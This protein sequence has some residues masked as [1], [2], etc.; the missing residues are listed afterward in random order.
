MDSM[1]FV[2]F[3]AT[4]DLAKRKIFPALYN[5]YLD[6]KLPQPISIIGLGRGNLTHIEFQE[7]V[8]ESILAFSRRLE[9]DAAGMGD[10]LNAFRYS[11][12]NVNH[13]EDYQ[14]LLQLVK[15][16]EEELRIKDNRMFYLSVAPEFFDIIALNIRSSGLGTTNGWKRLMIEKPFGHDLQSARELNEKLSSAF[17]EEEIFRI[18]HYLGKPMVQN[19]EALEFANP[20][21]Q[22]IWNRE[23]IANVQITASETV[24]VETRAGYYDQAGAIRDMVQNHMLQ[25]L[26][27]TA[28]NL[29]KK[30]SA[31]EIRNEKRKVMEALRPV[32]KEDVQTQIVRGQYISGEING[33]KV[34]GYKDEPGVEPNSNTDTFIATRIWI[35]NPFWTGVPFYIRTGKR[36]REKSTRIV[37]EFKNTIEVEYK[38]ENQKVEPNLLIIEISPGENV[39]L[40]LN[41]KNPMNNGN[42][43]PVRINFSCEDSVGNGSGVPEAYERLIYDALIG[44]S[45]FFAHWKEVELSWEW[46]QPILEAFEGNLLLLHEYSSGSY[47]PNAANTLL[48]ENG[49]KWWLD[50]NQEKKEVA[51]KK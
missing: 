14:R 27:M 24:G 22:S 17:D 11:T 7:K 12:L 31:S 51:L 47:G 3:G 21:L 15:Q 19:L 18:D 34:P 42:I 30:I 48:L 44:D 28:M 2:L 26:M 50:Q 40:Q 43:E 13:T 23:H 36:M 33:Q 46:V 20:V 10:F 1:T 49:F 5:L 16:R 6:Q 35:D 25:M 29:P 45:T 8:K 4:G 41:S 32:K 37:I 39:S 9:H 38:N